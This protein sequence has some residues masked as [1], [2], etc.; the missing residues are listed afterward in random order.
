M[1]VPYFLCDNCQTK[2]QHD[3]ALVGQ[4][5]RCRMCGYVFRVPAEVEVELK[6]VNRGTGRWFLRFPN[7]R[8]FGPV[9]K[10]MI[11]EWVQEGRA[12]GESWIFEEGT[13]DWHQL[14]EI[15]PELVKQLS[16]APVDAYAPEALTVTRI[17][18]SGL[19]DYWPDEFEA[20]SLNE[21]AAHHKVIEQLERECQR[22]MGVVKLRGHRSV[23]IGEKVVFGESSRLPEEAR[24]ES[25][26]VFALG[27]HTS[28]FY[29]VIPWSK[30]GRLPHEFVSI[31]P[32]RLPSSMAL[33]RKGEEGFGGGQWVGISGTETD[34]VAIAARRSQEGLA[35]G[36]QWQWFSEGGDFTM[37][38][39]WGLQ[40]IPLGDE[41]FLHIMQTASMGVHNQDF[42]LLWYL[43]RQ[44][45][46]YRF[47]RRL[48]LPQDH[49]THF[50][51]STS[52]GQLFATLS[53][54]PP[55]EKPLSNS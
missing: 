42:G 14:K 40:A 27:N 41:K 9:M 45:A 36:I 39:V 51:F 12:D 48:S 3:A 28:E 54:L 38:L 6:E 26:T 16:E 37:V 46:F 21:Q 19:L 52:S 34:V 18:A 20:L 23:L 33:R 15:F 2:Y 13:H 44:S 25:L 22:S 10:E 8:Q 4:A 29:L 24:P 30:L 7:G 35:K 53:N 1:S 17:P 11:S 50:L 32:G 47:S 43:E 5:I 31:L 55:D 49:E